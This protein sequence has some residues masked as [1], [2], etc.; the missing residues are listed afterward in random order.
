MILLILIYGNIIWYYLYYEV[1][2]YRDIILCA[3]KIVSLILIIII[4]ISVF[5]NYQSVGINHHSKY[6]CLISMLEIFLN[7]LQ[8]MIN[9]LTTLK[10]LTTAIQFVIILQIALHCKKI[11]H[12]FLFHLIFANHFILIKKW[13]KLNLN[14]I[15]D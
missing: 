10:Q 3:L 6:V 4:K 5:I 8:K 13:K 11:L 1:F 15:M 14:L 7:I 2:S 9:D 12:F